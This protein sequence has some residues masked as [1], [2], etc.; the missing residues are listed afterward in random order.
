MPVLRLLPCQGGHKVSSESLGV[1]ALFPGATLTL[2]RQPRSFAWTLPQCCH[3]VSCCHPGCLSPWG[4]H[5]PFPG[6]PSGGFSLFSPG[7]RRDSPQMRMVPG[8]P[9]KLCGLSG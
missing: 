3:P 1:P 2:S 7:A 4:H 8:P 5:L 6:L 9:L